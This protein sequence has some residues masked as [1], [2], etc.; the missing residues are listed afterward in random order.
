[1]LSISFLAPYLI[2]FGILSTL[3]PLYIHLRINRKPQDVF[4]PTLRF[5]QKTKMKGQLFR[6]KQW[7]LLLLRI[8]LLLLLSCALAR[9]KLYSTWFSSSQNSRISNVVFI[10]DDTFSMQYQGKH[11]SH[12][13]SAQEK[14]IELLS[15]FEAPSQIC[16]FPLSRGPGSFTIDSTAIRSEIQ[17]LQC[18]HS[19]KSLQSALIQSQSLLEAFEQPGEIIVLSDFTQSN[20]LDIQTPSSLFQNYPVQLY[21]IGEPD[22]SNI[23][24]TDLQLSSETIP[25]NATLYISCTLR[26]ESSVPLERKVS[27]FIEGEE[28]EQKNILFEGKGQFTKIQFSPRMTHKGIVHGHILVDTQDPLPLDH[29][30]AFTVRVLPPFRIG[31]LAESTSFEALRPA[32]LLSSLLNPA[33]LSLNRQILLEK[34]TPET[35]PQQTLSPL[36][37]L[38]VFTLPKEEGAVQRFQEFLQNRGNLVFFAQVDPLYQKLLPKVQHWV[39][40]TISLEKTGRG[41]LAPFQSGTL[42]ALDQAIFSRYR[43]IIQESFSPYQVLIAFQNQDPAVTFQKIGEGSLIYLA[44]E[45]ELHQPKTFATHPVVVPFFHLLIRELANPFPPI[46]QGK[47]SQRITYKRSLEELG[48]DVELFLPH[49]TKALILKSVEASDTIDIE[50]THTPGHYSLFILGKHG[51]RKEGFSV[52]IPKEEKNLQRLD[53]KELEHYLKGATLPPKN[54]EPLKTEEPQKSERPKKASEREIYS[55]LMLLILFLFSFESLVSNKM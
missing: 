50:E 35:F 29:F 47:T 40:G 49:R 9:P 37:I 41:F 13:K 18:S 51:V 48:Q 46:P 43:K 52:N 20:F 23:S 7:L 24:I 39:E 11:Q 4:L 14:A 21:P 30:Y 26:C 36:D 25:Q 1:V 34:I 22:T 17:A 28:K 38:F 3:I 45:L 19:F 5:V 12:F 6:I 27:L 53:L 55:Y 2:G 31:I 10:L 32:F 16:L 8:L 15:L 42:G 44:F 33:G 54:E